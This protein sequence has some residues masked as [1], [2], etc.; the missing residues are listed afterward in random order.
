LPGCKSNNKNLEN[1]VKSSCSGRPVERNIERMQQKLYNRILL[2]VLLSLAIYSGS[3]AETSAPVA[4]WEEK[5]DERLFQESFQS[6]TGEIEF[7]VYLAEQADLSEAYFMD[8]K[9]E[10]GDFVFMTLTETARRTQASLRTDLEA[11]GVVH[12]PYWVANMIWVRA[13]RNILQALAMR[14]EVARIF[15][16]SNIKISEPEVGFTPLMGRTVSGVQWNISRLRAPAVWSAGYIGQGVVV[17]G[18]DTGYEWQHPALIEKYRGWDG[19][20]A[21]HDYNW[22]DAIRE[23]HSFSTINN[24]CGYES[25]IPCDDHGHGTHTMGTMVGDDGAG[26]Q[27]GIAPGAKWIGCRNMDQGWGKP[28]T[29]IECF[30]WFIAPYPYGGDSFAGDPEKAPDIIN[31]SWG[32][33]ESEGCTDPD[34]LETVVNNVRAAGILIVSSAGNS[35]SG[36]DTISTPP[37]IYESVFTIGATDTKDGIA[38]FS[39]RGPVIVDG[40]SRL[41]PDASAPGVN[42][43]SSLLDGGYGELSGTS[44][45]APHVAGMA[46]LLIS[47]RP[48]LAGH[49]DAIE[50]LIQRSSFPKKFQGL[51]GDYPGW[52]IPNPFYGWGR[53]D[54]YSTVGKALDW[55]IHYLPIIFRLQKVP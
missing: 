35:G 37:A 55:P 6:L 51:C 19:S 25:L 40:S 2:I 54:A 4:A 16:N 12:H 22:H 32:C 45:A 7:L 43:R 1:I 26:N 9:K 52:Q 11:W 50:E 13:N 28:S 30:E 20:S 31:N 36:C 21:N 5:V 41:K 42:I 15:A 23:P 46:A 14:E 8:G 33:P 39:S 3:Q 49:V 34:V 47:A 29:Y 53:V 44:M 18:Q 48:E 17:G 38:P 24:P 27:V 10:K